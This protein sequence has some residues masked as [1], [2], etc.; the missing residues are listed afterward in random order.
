MSR[1]AMS[2]LATGGVPSTLRVSVVMLTTSPSLSGVMT[3]LVFT[4]S[5]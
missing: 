2:D 4:H 5:G 3:V 1:R